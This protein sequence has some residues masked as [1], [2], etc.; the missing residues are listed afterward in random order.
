M[1]EWMNGYNEEVSIT[2]QNVG[3]PFTKITEFFL[4]GKNLTPSALLAFRWAL[5]YR[6]IS[7]K[8]E[9]ATSDITI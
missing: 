6:V 3:D 1:I 5:G 2:K 4:S 8:E 7:F 9:G